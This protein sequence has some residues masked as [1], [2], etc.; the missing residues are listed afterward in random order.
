MNIKKIRIKKRLSQVKFAELI[1]I[2]Q[3][4]LSLLENGK[5]PVSKKVKLKIKNSV[6]NKN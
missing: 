4:L 5:V 6:I 1:G 2:S 3:P